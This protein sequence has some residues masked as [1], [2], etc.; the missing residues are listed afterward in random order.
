MNDLD[1]GQMLRQ[2]LTSRLLAGVG[3]DRD[4]LGSGGLCL[5]LERLLGFV[6]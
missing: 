2:W 1:P 5:R 6:E 3:G 4:G